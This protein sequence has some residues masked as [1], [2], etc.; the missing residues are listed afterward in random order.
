MSGMLSA[1]SNWASSEGRDVCAGV[2]AVLT[3]DATL[4]IVIFLRQ[5]PSWI[6]SGMFAPTGTFCSSN[7]PSGAVFVLTSGD[8]LTSLPHWPHATPGGN[9]VTP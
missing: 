9:G 7:V 6:T 2:S 3:Q 4:G 5:R 1:G 8:P